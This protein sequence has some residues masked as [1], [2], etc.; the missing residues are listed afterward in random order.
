[1][2]FVCVPVVNTCVAIVASE[3]LIMFSY[4]LR[5]LSKRL[6]QCC[7]PL[8][9]G[10]GEGALPVLE[11]CMDQASVDLDVRLQAVLRAQVLSANR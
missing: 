8:A 9:F 7:L 10:C 4:T 2:V 5:A 11:A 1:M 3:A 6:A